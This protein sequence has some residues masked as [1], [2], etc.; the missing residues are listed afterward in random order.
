MLIVDDEESVQELLREIAERA[1]YAATAVA[2]GEEAVASMAQE[3]V[4]VVLL[5]VRMPGVSGLDVLD[6]LRK[7]NP[8]TSVIIA[9]AVAEVQTVIT[10]MR[11][12][13]YDYVLKP[14][15]LEDVALKIDRALERRVLV[16]QNRRYQQ[17]LEEMVE[18]QRVRLQQ[19]FKE[20]VQSLSRE[21]S[22]YY[23]LQT[24]RSKKGR[25]AQPLEDLPPDLRKPFSSVQEFAAAVLRLMEHGRASNKP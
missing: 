14:F 8:D 2:S 7:R 4:D 11:S 15:N 13:A 23:E 6:E 5:D 18:E 24:L 3:E 12:G 1:G 25:S 21:H 17:H 22:A 20:L 19:Q 16:M 10:A 9:T